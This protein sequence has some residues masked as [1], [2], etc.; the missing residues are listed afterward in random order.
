MN[1]LL[2]GWLILKLPARMAPLGVPSPSLLRAMTFNKSTQIG[3]FLFSLP[4]LLVLS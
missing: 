3:A 1:N 2:L 4:N